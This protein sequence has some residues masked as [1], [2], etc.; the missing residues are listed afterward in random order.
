[1][2]TITLTL[3]L[4]L[5]A[6]A[7]GQKISS[8]PA[9][10]T[11]DDADL[12]GFVDVSDTT[13][14]ASG[15]NKKITWAEM[16]AELMID[17][18]VPTYDSAINSLTGGTVNALDGVPTTGLAVGTLQQV[19]VGTT[20]YFYELKASVLAESSPSIIRPDDYNASTNVKTWHLASATL[21]GGTIEGTLTAKSLLIAHTGLLLGEV[22]T[23]GFSSAGLTA[24]RTFTVPDS[25][26]QLA[27]GTSSTAAPAAAPAAVGLFHTD[28]DDEVIYVSVG[29]AAVDDWVPF[30][31]TLGHPI[32]WNATQSKFQKLT[33]TGTAGSETITVSDL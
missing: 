27:V 6:L 8:L 9:A 13:I 33:I 3:W 11:T 15:T 1:M 32:G 26:G 19:N 7:H 30:A 21:A 23:A 5:V 10:S 25:A 12:F 20:V 17:L 4:A 29:T 28:T 14:A 22:N 16:V 2:K 24:A 18:D 31:T